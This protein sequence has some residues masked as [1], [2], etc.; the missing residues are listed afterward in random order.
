MEYL[1][2]DYTVS[3]NLMALKDSL[4]VVKHTASSVLRCVLMVFDMLNIF[5]KC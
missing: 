1:A 5:V 4:F 2:K 3:Q